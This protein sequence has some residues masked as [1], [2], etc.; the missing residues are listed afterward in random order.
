MLKNQNILITG[1]G[2]GLGKEAFFDILKTGAY[3]IGVTRSKKDFKNFKKLNGNY[4]IFFGDVSQLNT[5]NKIFNYCKKNNIKLTGLVNNAGIRQ[6]KKFEKITKKDLLNVMENNWI[7]PFIITQ[8]FYINCDKK[9]NCSIINIGS[10][11]GEKGFSELSGYG[12]SKSALNGLTKCLM[13]EFSQKYKNIRINCINPGFTKTSFYEK[14]KK[15]KDLFKWTINKTPMSRWAESKEISNLIIF[16]LSEKSNYI[17]G[18][19]I[20]IDGGWTSQ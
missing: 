20:N 14:F 3:V 1:V 17:N 4:K 16:L 11:V 15:N 13:S 10:I 18:Q 8:K 12:S 9:K 7:S 2:K 6:R 19:S 5:I